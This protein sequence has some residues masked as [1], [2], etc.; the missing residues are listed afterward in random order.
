MDDGIKQILISYD[1]ALSVYKKTRGQSH[2]LIQR[3][4][5][6]YTA[7]YKKA[8][9]AHEETAFYAD[10]EVS[11]LM[12]EI[13]SLL[14]EIA[15]DKVDSPQPVVFLTQVAISYHITY[16]QFP[17]QMKQ[18]RV[19]YEKIFEIEKKSENALTF[20]RI[21][22]E[23]GIFVKFCAQHLLEAKKSRTKYQQNFCTCNVELL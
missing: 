2:P 18:T 6:I 17:I 15:K 21:M 7:L 4:D 13:G 19:L 16:E 14:I 3:A 5:C 9:S 1:T 8:K 23:E 11:I 22:A 12:A 20:L 10:K